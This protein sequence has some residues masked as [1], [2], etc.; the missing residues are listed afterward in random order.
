MTDATLK[1]SAVWR[2]SII[3]VVFTAFMA[4]VFGFGM[5]LFSVV[6]TDMKDDIKFSY[7]AVGT[8][9]A[10]AQI[11]FLIASLLSGRLAR[12]IGAGR[13]IVGAV[14]VA[15]VA[16]VALGFVSSVW[17]MAILL[18]ILGGC[19]A[20]MVVPTVEVVGNAVPFQHRSKVNCLVSS[21][22]AYGQFINGLIVP[23]FILNYDWR[24][25]WIAVG[26]GALLVVVVGRLFLG[27]VAPGAFR[28]AN[29]GAADGDGDGDGDEAADAAVTSPATPAPGERSDAKGPVAR[30][31]ER[32]KE[33]AT[34]PNVGVWSL[35]FLNGLSC[36]P[37]QNYLAPFLRDE[38]GQSVDFTGNLWSVIGFLGL[39]S[40]FALGAVADRIGIRTMLTVSYGL[41]AAAGLLVA[42]QGDA[43][44]MM[45]A[46][47]AF[48]LAFYAVFGLVPSYISKTADPAEATSIFGIANVMLGLGTTVGNFLGGYSQTQLGSF[49]WVYIAVVA[50]ALTGIAVSWVLPSEQAQ[51]EQLEPVPE[52]A[53]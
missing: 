9:T 20:A 21:G 24:S 26:V 25:L 23:F 7:L 47:V 16:L 28:R 34:L 14:A 33:L 17:P 43:V 29:A 15:G 13:V 12:I 18:T 41:L 52:T 36:G 2:S 30:Q 32:M 4:I 44:V 45:S 22:T 46:A 49:V 11:A 3:A 42:V 27:Y 6:V 37:W 48:G 51:G 50:V 35:L 39:W 5:Y 19:A 40:G 38:L 53:A 8:I 1:S 31:L 10:S